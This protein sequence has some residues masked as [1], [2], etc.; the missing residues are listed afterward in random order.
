MPEKAKNYNFL[1]NRKKGQK[2]PKMGKNRFQDAYGHM[3]KKK[4]G[5]KKGLKKP[6]R[7]IF[8]VKKGPYF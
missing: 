7:A 2:S 3:G 1:K 8:G 4:R 6:K 5:S